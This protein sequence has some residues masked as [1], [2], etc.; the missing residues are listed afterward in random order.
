M[1]VRRITLEQ[2]YEELASWWSD[3]G[4]KPPQQILLPDV[5]V[6]A[7]DLKGLVCCAFLY[8]DKSGR[9][10]MIEWEATNPHCSSA[11]RRVR[12]L[13][14]VFDFMEKYTDNEN[15][16]VVLSWTAY[17]RGD[18]RIL[19]SRK[20]SKCEGNRHELMALVHTPKEA[21]CQL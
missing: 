11:F 12:G 16:P 6:V 5:G 7:Y 9:I 19:L 4:S 13:N 8:E 17:E 18:G 21:L 10:A 20:W 14:M 2:D 15:I 3:R 1:H